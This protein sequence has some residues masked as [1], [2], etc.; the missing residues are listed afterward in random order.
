MSAPSEQELDA[1][2]FRHNAGSEVALS[3]PAPVLLRSLLPTRQMAAEVMQDARS[4]T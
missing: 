2:F 1:L 4:V 3:L